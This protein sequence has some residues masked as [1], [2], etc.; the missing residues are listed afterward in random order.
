MFAP[1]PVKTLLGHA[2]RDD[3]VHLGAVRLIVAL[4]VWA[5][6]LAGKSSL[7]PLALR[8][9]MNEIGHFQ[10][11]AIC[12]L[13]QIEAGAVLHADVLADQ[14]ENTAHLIVLLAKGF[15][16]TAMGNVDDRLQRRVQHIR[17]AVDVLAAI[18]T[19]IDAER[20]QI[21]IAFKLLIIGIG[22][23]LEARLV[24]RPQHRHGI[25]AEV[26]AGHGHHMALAARNNLPQNFAETVVIGCRDMVKLIDG[27]EH[28]VEGLDAM[29]PLH[30]LKTEAEGGM[31]ADQNAGVRLHE[32]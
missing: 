23:R 27:E 22:D 10:H 3:N 7:H 4:A 15:R 30:C 9:I 11:A 26:G 17:Q 21:L 1:H 19:V 31:G 18:E 29:Q 2:K 32:V 12:R 20:L 25:A 6:D 8:A 14:I 24:F 28:I 13:D 16:R 5:F